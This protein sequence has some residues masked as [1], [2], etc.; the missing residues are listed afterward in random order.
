MKRNIW[1]LCIGLIIVTGIF[2]RVYDLSGHFSHIDDI[3]V[4]KTILDHKLADKSPFLAVP[5]RWTF[6][7]FQYF[8]TPFLVSIDHTYRQ[9]LFWGR[10]PSC[11]FG[12]LGIFFMIQFYRLYEGDFSYKTLVPLFFFCCTWENIIFSKLMYNY[13]LAVTAFVVLLILY[14]DYLK[15]MNFTLKKVLFNSLCLGA[16]CWMH[17]IFLYFVPV[18]YLCTFLYACQFTENKGKVVLQYC[19]GGIVVI[20]SVF[21]LWFLFLRKLIASGHYGLYGW[22]SGIDKE[23]VFHLP[24]AGF[25]HDI[26]YAVSFFFKNFFY[27]FQ[28]NTGFFP[29]THSIFLPL[30]IV[31]LIFF[32]IGFFRLL[33]HKNLHKRYLGIFFVVTIIVWILLVCTQRLTFSPTRHNFIFMPL[34]VIT[35]T[36]GL[37]LVLKEI[38]KR[39][40]RSHFKDWGQAVIIVGLLILFGCHYQTF[41]IERK[42]RL[43]E[44]EILK[45]VKTYNVDT[46]ILA[47]WTQ[48]VEMMKSIRDHFQFYET[49]FREDANISKGPS[50]YKRI[51]WISHRDKFS[52]KSYERARSAVNHY[53]YYT[54]PR[55]VKRNKKELSLLRYTFRSYRVIY[56][57]VIDS[58]VELEF[59]NRTHNGTNNLYIYILERN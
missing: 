9:L 45:I 41:L 37:Y 1:F 59:D 47:V 12:I 15:K 25:F 23:F 18:F 5:S 51:A 35:L 44:Q 42:D 36:E 48:Q 19:L 7:P 2:A 11:F 32:V 53:I 22:N 20:V 52:P 56:K 43:N 38:G 17:Y 28:L 58:D 21:P 57:K 26:G 39:I 8:I 49:G 14:M 6:A 40:G 50:T 55:R 13:A 16:L 27:I 33:T 4:A 46:I 34:I 29:N 31:F 3:G 10:L 54:N 30:S 24:E